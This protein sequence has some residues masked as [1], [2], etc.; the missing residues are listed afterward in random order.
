MT[1]LRKKS[2]IVTFRVSAD[3]YETLTKICMESAAR[4]ISEFARAAVIDR[5]QSTG[6]PGVNLTGD[7]TTLGRA[8]GDLDSSLRATSKRIRKLLG[9]VKSE[10]SNENL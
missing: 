6:S 5:L 2:R 7:L 8:L 1:I 10:E 3:E 9:P 4:S